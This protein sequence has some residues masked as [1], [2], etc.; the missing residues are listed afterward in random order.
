MSYTVIA[1]KYRPQNFNDL[2]GQEPIARTLESAINLKK[3]HHAYLFSGP[4]GVGKTST[5][6]ILAKALNCKT[7]PTPTPCGKC[8][9][10][11]EI[12]EG[13]SLDVIE[14]DG[15]SNRGI[16]EIRDLKEKVKFRPIS[17]NYKIYI[18]DEVHMLTKEAFNALLKTLEEPPE[19]VIF[20]FATT[21][22]HK[23]PLTVLSRCQRYNFKRISIKDISKQLAKILKSENIKFEDDA[24]FL[25]S[26]QADGSLRDA[27]SSLD[28]IIA[29][30]EGK[31]ETNKVRE[32][33]GLTDADAFKQFINYIINE[34]VTE[35]INLINS[36]YIE[37]RDL[38]LFV[39]NLMEYI[40]NIFLIKTG[41]TEPDILE[42][43]Q[44]EI[45]EL[46]I[47]SENFEI[48]ILEEMINYITELM[49]SFR[50]SNQFRTL[51]E[52]G[53]IRLINI[54]KKITLRFI[55]EYIKNFDVP[56]N[57]SASTSAKKKSLTSENIPQINHNSKLPQQVAETNSDLKVLWEKSLN[58]IS[59][60]APRLASFLRFGVL[61]NIKDNIITLGYQ[62]K[63]KFQFNEVQKKSN[64]EIIKKI[65]VKIFENEKKM[66]FVLLE[67]N[68]KQ[69]QTVL[70]K[71][72]AEVKKIATEIFKGDI[73]AI[74][75]EEI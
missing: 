9:N 75:K 51:L 40:R 13:R 47:I 29:F 41:I 52:I 20:I 72:V 7:G 68:E 19:H 17:S 5:A 4:R 24:L 69:R 74:E 71:E 28:Q 60:E 14:I 59:I 45:N 26:K 6:R 50:Y 1:R 70:P 8:Q 30:T 38:K 54:Y 37:G 53:F 64:L 18:I 21:E 25:I 11:I 61:I 58:H 27:Q 63:H 73:I 56:E 16:D 23:V 35:G 43:T 36:L 42:M 67:N 2:V 33:F 22:P 57:E 65:I 34:N 66:N 49:T 10:C 48:E 46:K 55:Y 15:A 32:M 3:I 44:D 31:I 39:S 62:K 12:A